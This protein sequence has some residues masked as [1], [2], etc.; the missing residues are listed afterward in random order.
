MNDK[1]EYGKQYNLTGKTNSI[2]A[3]NTWAE[4]EVKGTRN[5]DYDNQAWI[6]N[7]KYIRCGHPESMNCNC[8]GKLHEGES[9]QT[10]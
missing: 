9:S 10:I 2:A 6:V 3:G 4:S 7:G 5:Y 8:Y 1:P